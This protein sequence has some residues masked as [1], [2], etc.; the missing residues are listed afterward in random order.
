MLWCNVL[1]YAVDPCRTLCPAC[2]KEGALKESLLSLCV[3]IRMIWS[4]VARRSSGYSALTLEELMI[5]GREHSR[6]ESPPLGM[7][8]DGDKNI[9]T[10]P[11]ARSYGTVNLRE[12]H[13]RS[14]SRGRAALPMKAC[15]TSATC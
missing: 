7:R 13:V 6:K 9:A 12:Q 5:H 4:A 11:V 3:S 8:R 2:F 14:R 15:M 1:F 10:C